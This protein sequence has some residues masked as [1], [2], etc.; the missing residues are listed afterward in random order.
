M[1]FEQPN[2]EKE[3]N[4]EN[5]IEQKEKEAAFKERVIDFLKKRE[6]FLSSGDEVI[7]NSGDKEMILM[8]REALLN[9]A[10]QE[11]YLGHSDISGEYDG[12]EIIQQSSSIA[13]TI[14]NDVLHLLENLKDTN[15]KE[16]AL[17]ELQEEA[18]NISETLGQLMENNSKFVT[19]HNKNSKRNPKFEKTEEF[20]KAYE[21]AKSKY[22]SIPYGEQTINKL[23]LDIE[24]G[25]YSD[26]LEI[27]QNGA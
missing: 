3:E 16:E 13:Q 8:N 27:Y 4:P 23:N 18:K 11:N 24:E 26:I 6:R 25:N 14:D 17:K 9:Q 22:A 7:S 12:E 1:N 19:E 21:F 5:E 2:F 20:K 15:I 10:K